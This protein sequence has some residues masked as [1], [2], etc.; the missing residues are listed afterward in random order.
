M[1]KIKFT[2]LSSEANYKLVSSFCG[3]RR[4]QLKDAALQ[5]FEERARLLESDKINLSTTTFQWPRREK[6][7]VS[8]AISQE[9]FRNRHSEIRGSLKETNGCLLK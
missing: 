6:Q 4:R 7:G 5:S 9:A 1:E 8:Y 2:R 3:I